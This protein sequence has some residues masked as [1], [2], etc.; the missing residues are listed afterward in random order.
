M[1]YRIPFIVVLAFTFACEDGP[2]QV[3]KPVDNATT[4]PV[5][6]G[7]PWTPEGSRPYSTEQTGGDSIGRAR[8][9]D[10][11]QAEEQ[12]QAMVVAPII[13]DVSVGTIPLLGEDGQPYLADNLLGTPEMGLYCDPTGE[14]ADAFVWGPTQEVIVL[15]DQETRLVD[16][17]IAY[18]SYLGAMTGTVSIGG[19]S[20]DITIQPR[21]R[22][23]IGELELTE[24][25]SSAERNQ[26]AN[27]FLNEG[28]V[29]KMYGMVRET[30]FGDDP[31]PADYNCITT[32]LCRIVY[33]TPNQE[34]TPQDSFIIFE[35]SG[36]QLRMTP[37]GYVTFVYAEPVRVA[38]FEVSSEID[39]G[40]ET[41]DPTL[42]SL[43][44]PGCVI[45][46][47]AELTWAE[48]RETC[49]TTEATL[50]RVGFDVHSQRDAVTAQF[51]GI[52]LDFKR[53]TSEDG[54]LGDGEA[55]GDTDIL[56]EMTW[57][58]SMSAPISNYIP[59][60][61][62][63]GYRSRLNRRLR[64]S[65]SDDAPEDH[66]LKAYVIDLPATLLAQNDPYPLDVIAVDPANGDNTNW[67]RGI[68]TDI[69]EIYQSLTPEQRAMVDPRISQPI[70]L[71]EPFVEVAMSQLSGGL[72]DS[73]DAFVAL[74]STDDLNWS[75][76][77][78][79]FVQDGVAYRM[80]VQFS[81]SYGAVTAV[82]ISRGYSEIDEIYAGINTSVRNRSDV[83]S[84]PY[85]Q[86]DLSR[87]D[88]AI[89]PYALGGDA[90]IVTD[91]DRQLDVVTVNAKTITPSGAV[92]RKTLI[93]PG[94]SIDDRGGYTRQL[95][96]ERFEFVP[97]S[98]VRLLGKETV[99]DFWVEADGT[100]GSVAEYLFK[101]EIKLC[102]GPTIF[103][104]ADPDAPEDSPAPEPIDQTLFVEYG[105]D[106]PKVLEAWRSEVGDDIYRDCQVLFNYSADGNV[107]DAVVSLKTKTLFVT[108]AD[109]AVTARIWK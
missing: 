98:N 10:E 93:V 48:F 42:R 103:P 83:D 81:N 44:K 25:A 92:G 68:I 59:S 19:E 49:V 7:A 47:D 15:F 18:Q 31:L 91:F 56:Y 27:S 41:F 109:R 36:I 86:L 53:K 17:V 1:N 26:T 85:Y 102:D 63:R 28:N 72:T 89:N 62:A 37:D 32:K 82:T 43:S 95:A 4:V 97:A 76:G 65:I 3:F 22:I 60:L 74:R 58:L 99:M 14:Y 16:A 6:S 88:P 8:F 90:M 52:S 104:P 29:T 24:Y 13:P 106:L 100:V 70:Y 46:L 67:I 20:T 12:I 33:T 101:G 78:G 40:E 51:N 23:K 84:Y 11:N 45:D 35:D 57:T 21:E 38:P 87:L 2:E 66:P 75:I 108:V 105:D 30:F 80:V 71:I 94:S 34:T 50:N 61:L 96:G 79:H 73:P 107:L 5:T 77:Y 54:I 69:V 64:D 9:C 39:L 55:P